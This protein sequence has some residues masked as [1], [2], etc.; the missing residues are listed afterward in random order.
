M[1]PNETTTADPSA[2]EISPLAVV[3]A[4]QASSDN[5][6]AQTALEAASDGVAVVDTA[7][8]IETSLPALAT[9]AIA[10]ITATGGPVTVSVAEF[11]DYQST[12][13]KVEGGFVV[14]DTIANIEAAQASLTADAGH[15]ASLVAIAAS[16]ILGTAGATAANEFS[17]SQVTTVVNSDGSLTIT[18][19][20]GANTLT[21]VT[22]IVLSNATIAVSG[23]VLTTDYNDGSKSVSTFNVAGVTF[24]N[25]VV[26]VGADGFIHSKLYTGVTDDFTL[27]WFQYLYAG[28]N[29]IGENEYYSGIVGQTY[30][31]LETEDDGGGNL[32][33]DVYTGVS[34]ASYS[35]YENDYV[36]GV[37]TSSKFLVTSVPAGA[38][39][40]SYE[41]DY[42]SSN[43]YLG[44]TFFF[45]DVTG[46]A[47]T[48][49][50]VSF[51]KN[52]ALTG[53]VLTGFSNEP[54]DEIDQF[55]SAGAYA[56][57]QV[58]YA[59]ITGAGYTGMKVDTNAS[60][61]LTYVEY[62]GVTGEGDLSSIAEDYS[63]GAITQTTYGYADI[64]GESYYA[65][66]VV[67]NSAG[68]LVATIYDNNDGTTSTVGIVSGA[69]PPVLGGETTGVP[70]SGSGAASLLSNG[71]STTGATTGANDA[72]LQL[73]GVNLAGADFGPH[74][75]TSVYGTDYT[76]PTDQEIDYYA[77]KG[78]NVIRVP[79]L[80]ERMQTTL[81]GPLVPA[82]LARLTSVVDY[83]ASKGMK[84]IIDPH[85]YASYAGNLIGSAAVPDSAFANFWGQLASSFASNPDVIFGLMNEPNQQS[86]SDWLVAA[87]DAIAAIRGAGANQE[88]LVPGSYWD[89]A[90]T[91]NSTDNASV[92]GTGV[93]DP[94]NNYAFDVHQYL[95]PN[96]SGTQAGV[97]SVTIGV[98]RLTSITNWA[99][100]HNAKLFLSE[101]GVSP[102][103]ESLTAMN[104]M[105]TYMGQNS[106]VWQG[107]T[108]WAGGPWWWGSNIYGI[109]PTGLGTSNVQDQPQMAILTQ[110]LPSA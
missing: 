36:G 13:D 44:D 48:N 100:S 32:V 96:G 90:W 26:T 15:I 16:S 84:T 78:L 88:V 72:G 20:N 49:E 31:G 53:Y 83:A 94:D 87:N 109:E 30:S 2:T 55:Y 85:D 35:S 8:G 92:V 75:T 23:D 105:L 45:A 9:E 54:Y 74:T 11:E 60:G 27:S 68:K 7:A 64:T 89:G 39:Y 40:S 71:A 93:E 47:Y 79:F 107:A 3:T 81:D 103:S 104:N 51:D 108:Y 73:L 106:S 65:K 29:L 5:A 38:A 1:P 19:P 28:N 69:T 110:H 58:D 102:D 95:D 57:E 33:R 24:T 67:D 41:L 4:A 59:G 22:S 56:G 6:D 46:Q 17:T 42:D 82:E 80:W 63:G 14:S 91:W 12:L 50:D 61:A 43:N 52:G 97:S 70:G 21:G 98:D 10:S 34:G 37:Y 101:F 62:D 86:A 18:S 99:E 77:S 25:S 66:S 76:Y